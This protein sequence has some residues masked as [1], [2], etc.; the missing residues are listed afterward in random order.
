M[1]QQ[2]FRL[3]E[4]IALEA[5]VPPRTLQQFFSRYPWDDEA[6]GQ[7]Q[8]AWVK[9]KYGDAPKITN[10]PNA[11]LAGSRKTRREQILRALEW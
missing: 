6:V 4:P 2:W 11:Y 5:G 8:R 1:S 9:R 10:V 3:I 7:R